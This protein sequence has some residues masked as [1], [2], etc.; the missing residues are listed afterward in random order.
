MQEVLERSDQQERSSVLATA[1]A[2]AAAGAVGTAALDSVDWFLWD[3]EDPASKRQTEEV[4]PE[5]EPPADVL[6]GRIEEAAG[7]QVSERTHHRRGVAMHFAI[8]LHQ[9]SDMRSRAKSCRSKA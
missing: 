5:G 3:R 1:L 4:R 8:G 2:G 9:Q 6:V 7:A